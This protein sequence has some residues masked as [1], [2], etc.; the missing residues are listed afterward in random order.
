MPGVGISIGLTRLFDVFLAHNLLSA[1]PPVEIFWSRKW[2]SNVA[3]IIWPWRHVCAEGFRV[4][5]YL[6][7]AKLDKQLK[8]ADKTGVPF[9][10]LRGSNEV[11]AGTVVIK[12][13]ARKAQHEVKLDALVP[14]LRDLLAQ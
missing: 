13:M 7:P 9:V 10:L 8:Y 14:F 4:E 3:E 2:K 6:E 1:P 12:D 11:E 5:N